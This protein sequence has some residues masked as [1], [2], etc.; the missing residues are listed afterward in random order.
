MKTRLRRY[1]A[2]SSFG[3]GWSQVVAFMFVHFA[4][5]WVFCRLEDVLTFN[6]LQRR[7]YKFCVSVQCDLQLM[8][9]LFNTKVLFPPTATANGKLVFK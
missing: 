7:C 6:L 2:E 4:G 1:L 9:L 3:G 8:I 5:I